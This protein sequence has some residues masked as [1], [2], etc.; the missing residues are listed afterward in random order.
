MGS[1]QYGEVRKCK[2]IKTG[3][4]RA[5]KIYRKI[6]LNELEE[7][8]LKNEIAMSKNFDH[9]HLMKLFE[10]YE[11]HRRKYVVTEC[12]M[13]GELYDELNVREKFQEPDAARII[14]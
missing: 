9:P 10:V 2:H 1:S 14:S 6:D 5:V 4:V 13:G 12:C 8:R 11:D 3:A 7:K